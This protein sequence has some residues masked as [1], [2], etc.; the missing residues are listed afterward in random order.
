MLKI[1]RATKLN[2]QLAEAHPAAFQC[3]SSLGRRLFF[4]QGI[5]VQAAEAKNCRFNATI[6]QLSDDFGKA[7]PLPVMAES[8][9][10]LSNEEVFLYQAQGG[11]KDL[12]QLW[13][14]RIEKE[15]KATISTPVTCMGLTQGLSIASDLFVDSDTD[16]LLPNPRWGNYD[17]IFDTRSQGR[18]VTYELMSGEGDDPSKWSFNLAG[19]AQAISKIQK[20]GVLVLNIPSNPVGYT[21]NLNECKQLIDVI[22]SAKKPLVILLDEAYKG[23]E[24]DDGCIKHSLIQEL[25]SLEPERFLVLKIDGATKEM[26]F[27]GGRIAFMTF[28]CG[29]EAAAILEE[30][31]I[32]SIRSSVSALP[33]PSQAMMIK[34]LKSPK[35]DA[36]VAEIRAMLKERYLCL[37]DILESSSL[38]HWKFNS[39]FFVLIDTPNGAEETRIKLLEH[40]VGVVSVASIGAIRLSYSTVP[41]EN[42]AELISIIEKYI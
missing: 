9:S 24:W 6:G 23:M 38:T 16:V 26:F 36:E 29:P 11:R 1:N 34:A 10:G 14:E 30:K 3:L 8:I 12:R 25:S 27:F 28:V 22:R 18:I 20:K 4:P 19:I 37:K 17:L 41:K 2:Q 13:K 42:L 31:V 35:L 5:P 39:A 15:F 7:L 33:S 40:D 21:P 32:A